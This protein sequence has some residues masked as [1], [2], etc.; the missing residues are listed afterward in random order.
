MK[1]KDV[2]T[3]DV[4]TVTPEA[5]VGEAASLLNERRV[6]GAPVLKDGRLVGMVT[7]GD[8]IRRRE[9]GSDEEGQSWWLRLLGTGGGAQGYIK[10]HAKHI[11]DVMTRKPVTVEEAT[12]VAEIARLL[13]THHIKRVPVLRDGRLVGVVSRADLVRALAAASIQTFEANETDEAIRQ[14]LLAELDRQRWWHGWHASVIVDNGIVHLWGFYSAAGE[15]DAA[16]VAAE[17]IPGVKAVE[18]HSMQRSTLVSA[19]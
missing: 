15:R 14:A 12:P 18:D 10:A 2:M 8:L 7:E 4:V 6:S 19:E 3:A 17:N 1:A 11:A 16:R 13:E 5:T 9:I